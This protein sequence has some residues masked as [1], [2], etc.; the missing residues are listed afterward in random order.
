MTEAR[1]DAHPADGDTV[2]VALFCHGGTVAS[3][4]PPRERALSVIRMRAVEQFVSSERT[5]RASSELET[6][7]TRAT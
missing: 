2:A 5:P 4:E 3:V 6:T 7:T 1:L